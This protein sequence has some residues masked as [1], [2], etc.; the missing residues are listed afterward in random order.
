MTVIRTVIVCRIGGC[1][2]ASRERNPEPS[3]V[4]SPDD[5]SSMN[6]ETAPSPPR[7]PVEPGAGRSRPGW[8]LRMTL[9]AVVRQ[10]DGI[11]RL[12]AHDHDRLHQ[13]DRVTGD[14]QV[15]SPWRPI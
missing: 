11:L 1:S 12:R 6:A 5:E 10:A 15:K 13:Q 7:G 2:F 3:T 9:L 14:V 4:Y 8:R